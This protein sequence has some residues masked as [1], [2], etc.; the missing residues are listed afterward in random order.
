[1]ADIKVRIEVNPNQETEFLGSIQNQ[2]GTSGSVENLSNVSMQTDSLAVFQNIPNLQNAIS[3]INGLSLGQDLVFDENGYLDNQDLQGAVI[4]DEQNPDEFVWGVVPESG[5][6]HVKLTFINAQNLKDII[7][8][9]DS[10]VGQFPTQAIV[11]GK[12]TI[13]SDDSK[14]AINL[15]TESNTHTIEFTHW[16][17]TNYNACLTLIAVMLRYFEVDKY[18]GLKSVESLSQSTGQPKE[19]F[20]GIVPSSGSLEIIDINGEIGEMV[21]D[22]IIPN[23]NVNLDII[24]NNN[25]IQQHIIDDSEYSD[26]V[27]SK[28]LN[29][30]LVDELQSWDN[31]NFKGYQLNTEQSLYNVLNEILLDFYTQNEINEMLDSNIFNNE[32]KLVKVLDYLQSITIEYPY[33][34]KSTLREAIDKICVVAQLNIY[35]NQNNKIKFVSSRP[36][37][38]ENDKIISIPKNRQNSIL[39]R[40]IIIKNKYNSVNVSY[41]QTKL[42]NKSLNNITYTYYEYETISILQS[43]YSKII[44]NQS[45]NPNLTVL[46]EELPSYANISEPSSN[47]NYQNWYYYIAKFNVSYDLTDLTIMRNF[48]IIIEDSVFMIFPSNND[49]ADSSSQQSE[50]TNHIITP[51]DY[52]YTDEEI[53]SEWIQYNSNKQI[54]EVKSGAPNFGF[55]VRKNQDNSLD[56]IYISLFKITSFDIIG[57]NLEEYIHALYNSITI[58]VLVPTIY[59]SAVILQENAEVSISETELQQNNTL[60]NNIPV[61]NIIQNNIL[62]DY[63]NGIITGTI[64]VVCLDYN[65]INGN[66][67]KNWSN[68]EI[69]EVGDVVRIDD[70]NGNSM[71]K[72]INNKDIYFEV[73]G[74]TFRKNGYPLLNLELREAKSLF[75]SKSFAED[76]W[77]LIDQIAQSGM[78]N[79]YYSVGDEKTITLTT[80]EQATLVIL[81]FNHDITQSNNLAGITMGMKG[82]LATTYPMNTTDTNVGGWETSAMR[83]STMQTIYNQLPVDLKSVVKQVKKQTS[84]GTDTIIETND[85]LW[86][87]SQIEISGSNGGVYVGEGTQYEYWKQHNNDNDR[88][89]RFPSGSLASYWLRSPYSGSDYSFKIVS[90]SGQ[91]GDLL[92]LEASS[93]IGVSFA[94]CI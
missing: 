66:K 34:P 6:Y 91:I 51:L 65:D 83:K 1:M 21:K 38:L 45:K 4:E 71:Y 54:Y 52:T 50:T 47:L 76:S 77:E 69:I 79:Q 11:D 44:N 80:G 67:I 61:Y 53:I 42:E 27:G 28:T 88:I 5:E 29:L 15:Q 57:L 39:N 23:S 46:Y 8:R 9:G 89:K 81:D 22:N 90:G 10:V 85:Y 37:K 13:Y 18:N 16:N 40:D 36:L 70:E 49:N 7:V 74:R 17:R 72:Y 92:W 86:L 43:N 14:W 75:N 60:I 64:S 19:I 62:Y 3:G 41:M 68:G 93:N 82:V 35:K 33:L 73:I 12:T 87:L 20:Y 31:I 58:N 2:V 63:S 55:K 30:E 56:V 32:N 59:Q 26:K 78:A 24:V 94:L 48:D 25:L 84:N